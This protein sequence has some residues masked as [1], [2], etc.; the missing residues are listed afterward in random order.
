MRNKR[1]MVMGEKIVNH[2]LEIIYLL[3]GEIPA[4]CDDVA[5]YFSL[6]EC[7]YMQR[8]KEQFQDVAMEKDQITGTLT[9]TMQS[10]ESPEY[11]VDDPIEISEIQ[12]TL[13]DGPHPAALDHPIVII[14]EDVPGIPEA[15]DPVHTQSPVDVH[16]QDVYTNAD[17]AGVSPESGSAGMELLEQSQ[18]LAFPVDAMVDVDACTSQMFSLDTSHIPFAGGS[19]VLGSGT[20]SD[21]FYPQEQS[22]FALADRFFKS[23]NMDVPNPA[24]LET[25]NLSAAAPPPECKTDKPYKCDECGKQFD[26]NC[27]L[28]VHKNTHTGHKPH[29]CYECGDVFSSKAKL[30]VHQRSHTGEKPFACNECG[31]RFEYKCRLL[32]HQ[33]SHTGVKPHSCDQCG[34]HFASK[35]NLIVHKRSHTGEKPFICNQCGKPFAY[36]C[37]LIV[38]ERTHT[39]EKPHFCIQCGKTFASRASLIIHHRKHTGERPYNCKECEKPFISKAYLSEHMRIHSGEKPF[40]C[41]DCGKHFRSEP[42]LI[43][44]Q[45]RHSGE[46]PFVCNDCGKLFKYKCRLLVHLRTHTGEKSHRCNE[47]GKL[48]A[49]RSTLLAHLKTHSDGKLHK[50]KRCGRRFISEAHLLEHSIAHGSI[51][52]QTQ[53]PE[54]SFGSKAGLIRHHMLQSADTMSVTEA[55]GLAVK[56]S[57]KNRTLS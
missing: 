27:R 1:K 26:Y 9:I 8:H 12:E 20:A 18:P 3:T 42:N 28:V 21:M 48:L 14:D 13:H 2:A 31:K 7:E 11:C 43:F 33:S 30:L 6:E 56:E 4:K 46:K 23:G 50:C 49:S 22:I 41:Q 51:R 19:A 36:K 45:R 16:N 29:I 40:Q 5:V 35:A 34:K 54:E 24:F 32:V 39:G 25:M 44:H 17:A 52:E 15:A 57:V 55:R 53:E 47:C 10:P 37:R 38:H